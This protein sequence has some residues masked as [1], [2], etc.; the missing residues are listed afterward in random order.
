MPIPA[1]DKNEIREAAL[2]L[3]NYGYSVAESEYSIEYSQGTTTIDVTY[4]PYSGE[5]SVGIRFGDTHKF[6]DIGWIAFIRT[7]RKGHPEKLEHIKK[8]L[9]YV[10][11]QY[12]EIT[13]LHFCEESM[14]LVS[15]YFKTHEKQCEITKDTFL[16]NNC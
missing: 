8:L 14:E 10:R 5:S 3:E 11:E 6:F 7:G 2:F 16:K 13:D 9:E 4:P 12:P 15:D 1:K